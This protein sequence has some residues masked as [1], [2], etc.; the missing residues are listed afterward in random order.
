MNII[1]QREWLNYARLTPIRRF[2]T[3]L[4]HIFAIAA[5]PIFLI[6]VLLPPNPKRHIIALL[7]GYIISIIIFSIELI[8]RRFRLFIHARNIPH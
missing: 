1:E 2:K 8:I 3:W 5:F 4:I 6:F 7:G